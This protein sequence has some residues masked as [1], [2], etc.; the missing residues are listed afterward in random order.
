MTDK[1][2]TGI[3]RLDMTDKLLTGMFRL[4]VTDK[5]LT[6]MFCLDMTDKL[7]PGMCCLDMTDK[8]L[9]GMFHLDMT[10]KLLIIDVKPQHKQTTNKSDSKLLQKSRNISFHESEKV[11]VGNDQEMAQPERNSHSKNQGW[12]KLN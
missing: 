5:L 3:F 4:D 7:L 2:L 12:K 1:L 8:L 11:Q 10:D 9:T 6:G